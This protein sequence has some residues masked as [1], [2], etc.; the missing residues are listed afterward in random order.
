M[1]RVS[2]TGPRNAPAVITTKASALEG[3][4][5]RAAARRRAAGKAQ[6]VPSSLIKIKTS[7][8]I[9]ARAKSRLPFTA[10]GKPRRLRE[11]IQMAGTK[12]A[13]ATGSQGGMRGKPPV[14]E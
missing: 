1:G 12:Q 8:P 14:S 3:I 10:G 2:Q 9:P 5:K 13:Q 11:K 6:A 4:R 7:R